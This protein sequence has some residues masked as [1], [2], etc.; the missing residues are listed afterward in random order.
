MA[1]NK[2]KSASS[3]ASG[4]TILTRCMCYI[5]IERSHSIFLFRSFSRRFRYCCHFFFFIIFV[6]RITMYHTPA[7]VFFEIQNEMTVT[8]REKKQRKHLLC[9]Y[10]KPFSNSNYHSQTHIFCVCIFRVCVCVCSYAWP[11]L[12]RSVF[13][14]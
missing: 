1:I 5:L 11:M 12:V 4:R 8:T 3:F 6:A 2:Q 7:R 9:I 13:E 10:H 14:I